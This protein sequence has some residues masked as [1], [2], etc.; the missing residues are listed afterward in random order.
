MADDG[1]VFVVEGVGGVGLFS[2]MLFDGLGGSTEGSL[3]VGTQIG[4]LVGKFGR[5]AT[6]LAC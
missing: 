5:I 4:R 6:S 3:L 1:I 2:E